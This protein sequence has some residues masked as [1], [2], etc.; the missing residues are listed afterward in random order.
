MDEAKGRFNG[1]P[2]HEHIRIFT[3]NKDR[4]RP[5]RLPGDLTSERYLRPAASFVIG[6]LF[7]VSHRVA[8]LKR[9]RLRR[10]HRWQL[11][12]DRPELGVGFGLKAAMPGRR[13]E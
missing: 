11:V 5:D 10:G 8:T 4:T 6:R 3:A 9:R 7:G 2:E 12:H 1:A 13:D